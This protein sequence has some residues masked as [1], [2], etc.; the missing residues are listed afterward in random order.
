MMSVYALLTIFYLILL[1]IIQTELYTPQ[2]D[3][4]IFRNSF[5]IPF[6]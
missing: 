1:V 6:F 4:D 5:L 3:F 2:G